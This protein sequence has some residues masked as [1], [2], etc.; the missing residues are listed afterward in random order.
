MTLL[1][2]GVSAWAQSP[3]ADTPVFQTCDITFEL[4]G[5]ETWQGTQITAEVKS[6]RFRTFLAE[7]FWAGGKKMVLR[8]TPTDD[9]L[10]ELKLTSNLARF[11]KQNLR[12]TATAS[13]APGFIQRANVHHWRY[14]GSLKAHLWLGMEIW[15]LPTASD[16]SLLT[17]KNQ[18]AT[19]VR[20]LFEPQWPPDPARFDALEKQIRRLNADGIL[21][22]LVLAG[23]DGALTKALPDGNQREKYFRYAVARLA[24]FNVTWELVKDWE[25]YREARTLL[26]DVGTLIKR[27]DPYDHPR[28]AYPVGS[29]GAF[30]KDGWMTHILCN[31]EDPAVPALEHQSYPLP[32]ISIG[33]RMS[34]KVLWNAIASGSY[35]GYG[36]TRAIGE[37]MESTRFWELEPY[38]DVSNGKALSL[39]GTDYLLVVDRPGIVE[40]EV[41]KHGYDAA[42]INASTGERTPLK[43]YKGEHFIGEPPT[44]TGEWLLQLSREGRKEGMLKSYKFE[45]Q[46][47]LMQEAE[48]DPKRVPFTINLK[49]AMDLKADTPIPFEI[50]ITKDS[51]ATRFMQYLITADV[52]TEAQGMRVIGTQAKGSITLPRELATKFP[53]VLNLRIA[54]MNA[55]GKI[56]YIDRVVSLIP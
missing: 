1:F 21:V 33:K 54:G 56:Y 38:F 42:W 2:L 20:T 12:V 5:A 15:D 45:S 26:K 34:T 48:V 24:P 36:A 46:P 23:P 9:G 49:D 18:K 27:W 41:E 52:P 25:T 11:D 3:C 4:S 47:F 19:H 44:K 39:E 7:A 55:N 17:A 13:D 31:G 35:L 32:T 40:V 37:V 53:A 30:V 8:F 50:K 43:E 14:T 10:W 29:T 6:P 22:D 16:E 51:R 28:S